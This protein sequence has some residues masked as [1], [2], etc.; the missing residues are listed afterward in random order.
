QGL[1]TSRTRRPVTRARP[2]RLPGDRLRQPRP[3]GLRLT[4]AHRLLARPE[5]AHGLRLGPA[6][7]PGREPGTPRG[8]PRPAAPPRALPPHAPRRARGAGAGR[9]D[10]LHAPP[11]TGPPGRLA[12]SRRQDHHRLPGPLQPLLDRERGLVVQETL[13]PALAAED[14]LA[15][16]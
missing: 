15:R 12:H 1:R 7:L 10:G 8:A 13:E 5:P 4:R 9:D 14:D 6:L 16:E 3:R 11:A 2:D